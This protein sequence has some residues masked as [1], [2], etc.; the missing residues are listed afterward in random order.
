MLRLITFWCMKCTLQGS[1]YKGYSSFYAHGNHVYDK[2]G[3]ALKSQVSK[4]LWFLN[5][6]V[7]K[8][9]TENKE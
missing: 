2:E 4:N 5:D 6:G 8:P 7:D 3:K 9:E 1:R